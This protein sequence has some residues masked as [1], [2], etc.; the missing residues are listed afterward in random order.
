MNWLLR[1]HKPSRMGSRR[2]K[3]LFWVALHLH[4]VVLLISSG[5]KLVIY[6][7][8]MCWAEGEG[9]RY[10]LTTQL[11]VY[12]VKF[13]G[14]SCVKEDCFWNVAPCPPPYHPLPPLTVLICFSYINE[15]EWEQHVIKPNAAFTLKAYFFIVLWLDEIILAVRQDK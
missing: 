12:E 8:F 1:I 3:Q 7:R 5:F 11:E 15:V 10:R 13:A 6:Y 4:R 2:H 14:F 9:N